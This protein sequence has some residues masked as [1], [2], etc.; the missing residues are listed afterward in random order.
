MFCSIDFVT[1]IDIAL[2]KVNH[3]FWY[4]YGVKP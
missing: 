3:L 2:V 1:S 4:S